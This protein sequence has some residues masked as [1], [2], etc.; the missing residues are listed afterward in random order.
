MCVYIEAYFLVLIDV[1]MLRCCYG[2]KKLL[3]CQSFRIKRKITGILILLLLM[4]LISH[5]FL[6]VIIYILF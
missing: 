1:P 3:L 5:Y 2:M 6:Y 4:L